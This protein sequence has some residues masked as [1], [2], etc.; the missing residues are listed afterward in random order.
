VL[1]LAAVGVSLSYMFGWLSY[2]LYEKRFLE[3]K[4]YFARPSAARS[5]SP[6]GTAVVAGSSRSA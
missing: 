2:H 4:R 1:L 6:L 5:T 3:L